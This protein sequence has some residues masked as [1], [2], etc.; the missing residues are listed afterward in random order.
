MSIEKVNRLFLYL[1]IIFLSLTLSCSCWNPFN[2]EEKPPD[3]NNSQINRKTPGNCIEFFRQA[4]INMDIEKYKQCLASDF[5]FHL[6]EQDAYIDETGKRRTD[7]AKT[8][9]IEV[10][11]FLFSFMNSIYLDFSGDPDGSEEQKNGFGETYHVFRKTFTLRTFSKDN[12]E[13]YEA[14]GQAIFYLRKNPESSLWEIV[15]WEDQSNTSSSCYRQIN[16][17]SKKH[18]MQIDHRNAISTNRR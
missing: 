16:V 9:E 13:D 10:T 1:V 12:S 14:T 15:H 6:L 7:W 2:P 11:E 3:E 17:L 5:V 4:Y 18:I 8:T